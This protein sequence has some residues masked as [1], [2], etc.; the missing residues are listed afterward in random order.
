MARK[1]TYPISKSELTT[2]SGSFRAEDFAGKTGRASST[3]ANRGSERQVNVEPQPRDGE[4]GK[5]GRSRT[6][7]R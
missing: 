3:Y 4:S 5:A 1:A 2:S 7:R 6:A